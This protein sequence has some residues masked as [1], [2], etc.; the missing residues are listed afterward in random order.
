MI[1]V[2][3]ATFSAFHSYNPV[4]LLYERVFYLP[5]IIDQSVNVPVNLDCP[6]VPVY[7]NVF[8]CVPVLSS[9]I[10]RYAISNP[11][12]SSGIVLSASLYFNSGIGKKPLI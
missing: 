10:Y 6:S 7:V 1:S 4:S 11:I 5:I 8:N 9:H 2:P 3:S 12:I